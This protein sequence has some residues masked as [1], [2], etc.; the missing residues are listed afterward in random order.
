M[1]TINKLINISDT[2]QF[3][4]TMEDYSITAHMSDTMTY[5]N[6]FV[7]DIHIVYFDGRISVYPRVKKHDDTKQIEVELTPKDK[8]IINLMIK[9]LEE[10]RGR[11]NA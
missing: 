7:R 2:V 9:T 10:K 11:C 5:M 6:L 8:D 1:L 3:S 4:G